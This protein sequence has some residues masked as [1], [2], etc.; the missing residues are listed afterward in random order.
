MK[1]LRAIR[2]LLATLCFAACLVCLLV[3]PQMHPMAAEVARMQILLSS[4]ASS[5]GVL[6]VWLIA[7]FVLGRVY[8]S[9][10]CPIGI[11]SDIFLRLRRTSRRLNRPFSYRQR[12]P[13]AKHILWIYILCVVL[14]VVAVPFVA[15]V[16]YIIE[17]YNI[18][19]NAAAAVNPQTVSS[20]WSTIGYSAAFGA[21]IG[22]LSLLLIA[23]LSLWRGREFCSRWCPVGTALGLVQS[24]ALM[25]IEINPDKCI[26]CGLC[27]DNCRSQCIKVVSRYIDDTR[28]VRCFE[29]VANCPTG[30]IR[31]Q[32]NRNRPASPLMTK[33]KNPT[34]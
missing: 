34:A 23:G 15:A 25:H 24:R 12:S 4:A 20:T 30:A 3:G 1:Q 31:Y 7:T 27:E 9:T 17:P 5:A 22:I 8:C 33:S 13:M 26:S 18:A 10:F 2:I 11:F 16:P 14:G 6:A 19:R 21:V 28:C 32:L 29:C